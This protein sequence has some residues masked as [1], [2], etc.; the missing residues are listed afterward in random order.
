MDELETI[1]CL[2]DGAE[3]TDYLLCNWDWDL[4]PNLFEKDEIRYEYNQWINEWSRKSCTIFAAMWMLSDL[5]NYKFSDEEMKEVDELS[6]T[7]WR[8]R[9]QW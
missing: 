5:I 8:I 6:Y 3:N 4:L 9:W 2:G 7:K 1:W